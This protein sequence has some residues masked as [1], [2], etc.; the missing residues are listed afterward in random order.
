MPEDMTLRDWFAG[1]IAHSL[2]ERT[3]SSK[4]PAKDTTRSVAILAFAMA[5]AMLAA[6]LNKK[7]GE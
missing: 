6:R 7:E 5:D 3:F 2:V 1:Q 4:I